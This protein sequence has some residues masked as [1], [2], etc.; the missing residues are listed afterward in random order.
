[1]KKILK[2]SLNILVFLLV[3][4]FGY[5]MIHSIFSDDKM[6]SEITDND[7]KIF[8]SPY[9]KI[10]SFKTPSEI[11]CFDICDNT[12]F[13]ASSG[14]VSVF[15]LSGK[16][17][18]DFKTDMIVRDIIVENKTIYLL[19]P[20]RIDLYSI[21]GKKT[22]EW[23][24]CSNNSNY[25]SFTTT[26]DYVFV[27]DAENKHIW[28]FD[29]QGQLVR[30]I[31][32]PE[33]FIIPSYSFDI[34][35][36][37]DT[38]YCSNSGRHKIESYTLD[39]EFIASFGI[40]GTQ[41]GA[42][43]GCCNPVYL[44]KT[45]NGNILT[46]EKGNPRISCYSKEGEFRTVLFDAKMLGGGNAAYEIH[47]SGENIFIASKKTISVYGF[48]SKLSEKSCTGCKEDCPLRK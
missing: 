27:T 6:V 29:K 43:A 35:N 31:K 34:I 40:S 10:N 37:N 48:D 45:F 18:R 41:A 3:A 22:G 28:Q 36:I 23:K 46:S 17:Q 1:M 12:V 7:G 47:V 2:I 5:Y 33:S 9:K 11:I 25:C 44:E 16:H 30:I 4:G 26:K 39:G 13:V 14:K 19:F 21:E 24:A 42:F 8:F 38:I 32:S 15:D 20:A